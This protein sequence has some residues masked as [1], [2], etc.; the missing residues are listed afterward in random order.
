MIPDLTKMKILKGLSY[1]TLVFKTMRMSGDSYNRW[2]NVVQV[3]SPSFINILTVAITCSKTFP[4]IM[5]YDSTALFTQNVFVAYKCPSHKN[6]QHFCTVYT[7][8]NTERFCGIQMPILQQPPAF[9]Y[10]LYINAT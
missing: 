7:C 3:T 9:L 8:I 10:C 2:V 1:R 4:L 5:H 6:H